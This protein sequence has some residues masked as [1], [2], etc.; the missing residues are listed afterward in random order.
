MKSGDLVRMKYVSFWS[1]K[2]SRSGVPYT[3]TPVLVY[4]RAHNAVKLIFPDG[5]IKNDLAEYY[6]VI[7]T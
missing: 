2:N 5:S 7:K 4:E 1:K 3:E 6:E